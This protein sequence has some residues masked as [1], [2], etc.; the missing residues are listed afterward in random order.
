[1]QLAGPN[2]R[3]GYLCHCPGVV[4]EPIQ[5]Q[6]HVQHIRETLNTQTQSSQLTEP[7]WTDPGRKSEISLRELISTKLPPTTNPYMSLIYLVF[8]Q[9]L[10]CMW[11]A[12]SVWQ[13]EDAEGN[14]AVPGT[15]ALFKTPV[16][17]VW[18]RHRRER[19]DSCH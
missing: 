18:C 11:M 4:W 5:K 10:F 2:V 13:S 12:C 9:H 16:H 19:Y 17:E 15:A 1:M 6:A 14:T 8:L 3:A 7:L